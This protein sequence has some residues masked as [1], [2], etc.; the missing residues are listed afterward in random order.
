MNY[1]CSKQLLRYIKYY[2]IIVIKYELTG[3]FIKHLLI[4]KIEKWLPHT[5]YRVG[6]QRIIL[7]QDSF[8]SQAQVLK[9]SD[10]IDLKTIGK[11]GNHTWYNIQ[12][13][14]NNRTRVYLYFSIIA[15]Q[16]YFS[17]LVTFIETSMNANHFYNRHIYR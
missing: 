14:L 3:N 2:F 12:A 11:P 9:V 7:K 10:W 13:I 6:N 16:V 17:N 15:K 8:Q 1:Y 5:R 4:N